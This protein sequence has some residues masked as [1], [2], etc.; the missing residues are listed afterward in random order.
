M[1]A[2]AGWMTGKKDKRVLSKKGG[3]VED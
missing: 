1:K 2:G 3:K